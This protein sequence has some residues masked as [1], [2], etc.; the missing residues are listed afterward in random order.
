[1]TA[2]LQEHYNTLKALHLAFVIAWMAG[3]LY[4][5]RL[6]VYH[7]KHQNQA[8]VVAVLSTMQV[9]LLRTIM[10]PALVA[11]WVFATLMLIAN[12]G[13]F[14]QG[15]FHAKLLLVIMMTGVHGAFAVA[16]KQFEVGRNPL[17]ETR[18][19]IINEIP[20]VL[21][22]LIVLLAVTKAF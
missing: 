21:A 11:V 22:L 4:L 14:A 5:P 1:M 7:A 8:E 12:P 6:F 10:N 15:W 17:T 2:F 16:R 19:R 9:K 20:A 3:L 13:L 18:W